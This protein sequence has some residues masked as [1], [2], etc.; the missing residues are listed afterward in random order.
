M[1]SVY[2]CK[3]FLESCTQNVLFTNLVNILF[4]DKGFYSK[5]KPVSHS[6]SGLFLMWK[7]RTFQIA[8][9]QIIARNIFYHCIRVFPGEGLRES[10][11]CPNQIQAGFE[12]L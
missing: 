4:W 10:D 12:G 6:A 2:K 9:N 11:F 8:M 7:R 3:M 1:L 5:F